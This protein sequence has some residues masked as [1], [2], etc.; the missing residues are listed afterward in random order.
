MTVTPTGIPKKGISPSIW[1]KEGRL[2]KVGGGGGEMKIRLQDQVLSLTGLVADGDNGAAAGSKAP[3]LL[4][5]DVGDSVTQ[6]M[7]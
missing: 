3:N 4:R 6:T 1:D 7:P 5:G 2:R